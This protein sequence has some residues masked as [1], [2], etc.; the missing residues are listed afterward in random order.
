[1]AYF[2]AIEL[3]CAVGEIE[4]W[5][6]H[7]Q[8][9][10]GHILHGQ[11]R[12]LFLGLEVPFRDPLKLPAIAFPEGLADGHTVGFDP[13]ED[14]QTN[15]DLCCDR[16]TSGFFIESQGQTNCLW[17]LPDI[18][19]HRTLFNREVTVGNGFLVIDSGM[20]TRYNST[21]Q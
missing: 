9:P 11:P 18:L 4:R 3:G 5:I 15:A 20:S 12:G 13:I 1:M 16:L 14:R 8:Q 17:V 10:F 7:G 19:E 6:G 21:R 2:W